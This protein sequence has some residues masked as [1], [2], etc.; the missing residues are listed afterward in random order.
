MLRNLALALSIFWVVPAFA[1]HDDHADAHEAAHDDHADHSDGD[2]AEHGGHHGEV[3]LG[4]IIADKKFIASL[5]SFGI[6]LFVIFFGAR[7]KIRA[8]LENRKRE[9][10]EAVAEARRREEE[11]EAK[12]KEFEE[13][14]ARLD[15]EMEQIRDE[16]VKAGEAERDRIVADA[17]AKA[18]I[19]RKDAQFQIEQQM[20]Q[21]RADLTKETIEAAIGA[22]SELLREKTS[23]ADQQRLADGYLESIADLAKETRA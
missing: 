16:V 18:A 5:I 13:R 23:P 1:Q 4:A 11:A 3:T 9:I 2:H 8:A 6:L 21:L 22:A 17:E 7:R 12:R 14:L 20:K 10:E 19:M 15:T